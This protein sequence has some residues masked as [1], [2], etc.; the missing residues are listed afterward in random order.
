M[1]IYIA[2]S[3]EFDYKNEL[4]NP[5][6]KNEILKHHEIILPHEMSDVSSNTRDFY[7]QIDLVIA[8]CSYPSI[9]LG[10]ELGWAFDDN[11]SI[12]CIHRKEMKI[13][14]SIYNITQ[15]IYEY[16]NIDE[17]INIIQ[18]IINNEKI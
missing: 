9:G 16:S 4:Y 3:R 6:M 13:S 11:K 5:L 12:Y 10:I 2:H 7:K 1:K 8:E 17:M 14:S 15:N 18:D